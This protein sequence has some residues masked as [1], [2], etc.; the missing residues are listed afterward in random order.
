VGEL[1]GATFAMMLFGALLAWIIRKVTKIRN[2]PS[3]VVGVGVMTIVGGWLYSQDGH[4]TF[5][6]AW[7]IYLIGGVIALALMVFGEMH[8]PS[9]RPSE[10]RV[11]PLA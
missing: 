1:L 7:V 6:Q 5:V 4:Y 3:Y 2:I 8:R 9:Q 10:G 11:D